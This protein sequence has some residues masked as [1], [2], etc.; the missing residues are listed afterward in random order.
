MLLPHKITILHL[1]SF[2]TVA[3]V[4]NVI[5]LPVAY[6]LMQEW[7]NGFEYRTYPSALIFLATTGI[8][9]LLVVI[10][11]GYSSLRAANMNPV[12]VIKNQ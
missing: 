3:L 5:A 12:D 11:A 7:L 10:S 2:M 4:A 8:S 6:W 1:G 9:F